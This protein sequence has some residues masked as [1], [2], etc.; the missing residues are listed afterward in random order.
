M[1]AFVIEVILTFFLMYVIYGTAV[2]S[3]GAHAIAPLAIGLTITMDVL[4]GGPLT[5]A[6]MNPSRSFGPALVQNHWD[7]AW[8]YWLAPIISAVIAAME[9]SGFR[10]RHLYGL[11]ESFGPALVCAW[12]EE[13]TPLSLAERARL[14]A[15][16][17]VN[18]ITLEAVRVVDPQTGEDCAADGRTMGEI[19][20]RGNTI[21][22]GYLKNPEA[23]AKAFAQGWFHSGDLGVRHP[24]DYVE[25]KDRS[26]DI[27]I[28]GGEN[29]SSL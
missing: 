2:D 5:G 14:T 19:L 12:H 3:R 7:D 4:M 26:K 6:A 24:D 13:W 18:C 22:M 21:M 10:I 8:I 9:E 17:G 27:I 29:I 15:R 20:L 16:Q 1:H 25:V 28:S 11:T 23:S